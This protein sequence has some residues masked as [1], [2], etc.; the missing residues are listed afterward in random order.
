MVYFFIMTLISSTNPSLDFALIDSVESTPE[1]DIPIIIENARKAHPIWKNTPL[2]ERIFFLREIYDSF[3]QQ[4]EIL[5]QS[6]AIE[7]GMPIRLARDEVQYGLN[8]F[9]W[10]LDNAERY[11]TAEVVFESETELHTVHYESN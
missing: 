11:L 3:V 7:M 4:K 2:N 9:I 8:Y 5:A 10:Y 6:V 1:S